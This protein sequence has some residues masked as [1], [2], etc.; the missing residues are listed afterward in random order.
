M[1]G[2][3]PECSS[4][5]IKIAPFLQWNDTSVPLSLLESPEKVRFGET[6]QEAPF[7]LLALNI[8]RSWIVILYPSYAR[9]ESLICS[10]H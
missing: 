8:R 5:G 2:W 3:L 10:Y 6:Y 4:A 7:S 1:V 9:R